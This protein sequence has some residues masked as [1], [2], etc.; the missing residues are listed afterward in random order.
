MC[1]HVH[2]HTHTHIHAHSHTHTH[3]HIHAGVHLNYY[4][5]DSVSH[6]IRWESRVY[7]VCDMSVD[8][9]GPVLEHVKESYQVHFH[10]FTKYA[11]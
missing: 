11:C 3:T 5:G 10:V 1:K 8:I 7:F 4:N 6:I 2:A 9:N